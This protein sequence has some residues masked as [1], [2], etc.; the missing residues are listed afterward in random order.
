MKIAKTVTATLMASTLLFGATACSTGDNEAPSPNTGTEQP[1][2]VMKKMEDTQAKDKAEIAETT[3]AMYTYIEDVD[4]ILELA[5]A[6]DSVLDMNIK[7]E[8]EVAKELKKAAPQAFVFFDAHDTQT[9]ADSFSY[10]TVLAEDSNLD[11]ETIVFNTPTDAVTIDGD[12]ATV[13]K[14]KVES[15]STK[16]GKSRTTPPYFSDD[17]R[18][19]NFVKKD[20]KWLVKAPTVDMSNGERV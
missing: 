14:G 6:A 12:T 20:G 17:D 8:D 18:E 11:K 16:D 10:L 9:I 1:A 13:D 2:K 3:T 7:D 5:D 19:I 4:N 15:T